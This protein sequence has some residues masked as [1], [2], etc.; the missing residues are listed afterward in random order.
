MPRPVETGGCVSRRCLNYGVTNPAD[1]A[2]RKLAAALPLDYDPMYLN[3]LKNV[4]HNIGV[5]VV[6]LAFAHIGSMLDIV[7]GIREFYSALLTACG[8]IYL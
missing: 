5:I 6:G 1:R 8:C 2:L 7:F 4:L 3:L